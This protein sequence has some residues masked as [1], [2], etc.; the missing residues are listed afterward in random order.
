MSFQ[1]AHSSLIA[2][3][4]RGNASDY[5]MLMKFIVLGDTGTECF[6]GSWQLHARFKSFQHVATLHSKIITAISAIII[7]IIINH[8]M[9]Q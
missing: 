7:T 8:Q 4:S 2:P 5:D 9:P 6:A 3:M 1:E